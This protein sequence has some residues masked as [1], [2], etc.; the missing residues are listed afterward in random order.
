MI[1]NKPETRGQ[2]GST[3]KVVGNMLVLHTADLGLFPSICSK[4]SL[5]TEQEWALSIIGCSPDLFPKWMCQCR[6]ILQGT[7][8]TSNSLPVLMNNKWHQSTN[9]ALQRKHFQIHPLV[10]PT[11]FLF[12]HLFMNLLFHRNSQTQILLANIV[13]MVRFAGDTPNHTAP[14]GLFYSPNTIQAA[15][16]VT[17]R[18][19][20]TQTSNIMACQ[21]ILG[22][23]CL[24]HL[25]TQ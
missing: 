5:S 3:Q 12:I 16:F 11:M 4:W 19:L 22:Q 21:G 8:I 20:E 15:S 14:K 1:E 6:T 23:H 25:V 17:H 2:S 24:V 13:A 9:V 7:I 10:F 18:S